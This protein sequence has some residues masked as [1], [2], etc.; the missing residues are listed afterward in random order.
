MKNGTRHLGLAYAYSG[1]ATAQVYQRI[2]LRKLRAL[3]NVL[4]AQ[5][6]YPHSM[7]IMYLV[8]EHGYVA[9]TAIL[10]LAAAGLPLPSALALLTV[11]AAAA[12]QFLRI[13]TAL[14]V[15]FTAAFGGDILL[16]LGG[17]S[18]GWWLLAF[19][20]RLSANPESCIFRSS[21]Y[22]YRNGARTLLFAKFVP[23][24]GAMAAPLA[25]SLN[26]RFRRFL[27]L[28]AAGNLIYCAS[29][30]ALGYALSSSILLVE[31]ILVTASHIVLIVLLAGVVAYSVAFAIFT[32]KARRYNHVQRISPTDLAARLSEGNAERIMVIADVR[33]HGYYDPAMQRIK[34]SIRVE[35]NRLPDEM[36]ALMAFMQPDCELYLYC[37]CVREAT[38]ARVAH[39][40]SERGCNVRVIEGGLRA[41]TKAGFPMEP[42]PLNDIEHLP[43][44]E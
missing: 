41:W 24:I 22:F 26:M 34:N 32:L 14:L 33:S 28:D 7:N 42:V 10:L 36:D 1:N 6:V 44:F 43:H 29:W 4:H 21:N 5:S 27:E 16:F 12:Q 40:L 3:R 35:P 31:V 19:L 13:D 2:P 37:S 25:G 15:A 38:S 39:V 8:A 20:C 18:T 11:G 17:R 23:G 9:L 30:L